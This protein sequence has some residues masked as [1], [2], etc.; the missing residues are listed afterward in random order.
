M[1]LSLK[2]HQKLTCLDSVFI[3]GTKFSLPCQRQLFSFE[4]SNLAF[5]WSFQFKH[6]LQISAFPVLHFSH[7]QGLKGLYFLLR[8][9]EHILYHLLSHNVDNLRLHLQFPSNLPLSLYKIDIFSYFSSRFGLD[10]PSCFRYICSMS[11]LE[12]LS[13][14]DPL[15]NCDLVWANFYNSC[16]NDCLCVK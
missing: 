16:Q 7:I 6:Y 11:A 14:E 4:L 5:L 10:L 2:C 9:T 15:F 8:A 13:S 12:C 3:S 1:S